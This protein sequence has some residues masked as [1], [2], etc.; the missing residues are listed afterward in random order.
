MGSKTVNKLLVQWTCWR[1]PHSKALGLIC[2]ENQYIKILRF[3]YESK[4]PVCIPMIA[5][6]LGVDD[7][8]LKWL[9]D[10]AN[11]GT[12]IFLRT[13]KGDNGEGWF[14]RLS[15]IGV[16]ILLDH[17]SLEQARAS[18]V[19]ATRFATAALV[20]SIIGVSI[21]IVTELCF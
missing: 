14:F 4:E 15:M 8:E 17:D 7:K 5:K 1:T 10:E 20:V 19:S 12:Q 3:V 6:Y 13:H 11:T 16:Q 21:N 9:N 2:M 18:S